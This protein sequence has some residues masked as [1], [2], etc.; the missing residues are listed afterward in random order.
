LLVKA[1]QA[2]RPAAR[3]AAFR[4]IAS[5]LGAIVRRLGRSPG[6]VSAPCAENV[7]RLV[8]DVQSLALG[9]AS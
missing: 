2:F 6:A 1:N 8:G 9:V 3:A 4:K 5:K 7:E